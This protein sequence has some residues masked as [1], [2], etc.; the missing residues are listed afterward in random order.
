[1]KK[2][3]RKYYRHAEK[4]GKTT[5]EQMGRTEVFSSNERWLAL[6]DVKGGSL[7]RLYCTR[8]T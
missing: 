7:E 6:D 2:E 8:Y 1:M 3:C 5:P 4:N